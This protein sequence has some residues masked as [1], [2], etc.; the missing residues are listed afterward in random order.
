MSL[1][2]KVSLSLAGKSA[3]IFSELL[4]TKRSFYL[5]SVR[6][7]YFGEEEKQDGLFQLTGHGMAIS[8]NP[9]PL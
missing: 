5:W 9:T 1:A 8:L 2:V 6:N 7:D 4:L 3:E